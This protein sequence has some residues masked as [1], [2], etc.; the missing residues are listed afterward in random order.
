MN[1]AIRSIVIVGAAL[2]M[3]WSAI[4]FRVPEWQTAV[5][6]QFGKPIRT[7]QEPGLSWRI[8]FMQNVIFFEKRLLEYDATP[9]DVITKDKQQLSVDNF[10]RWRI[11]DPLVFHQSVLTEAQAQSRLDDVI[12]SALREIVA[13]NRLED[14]VSG[15][16]AQLVDYI[17]EE[18]NKKTSAFGIEI[19]DVR[20]KRTELPEKNEQSVFGRMRTERERQAKRFRAE[21][22]E[23]A[24]KIRS[25]AERERTV[26]LAEAAREAE[27]L[28]GK[29]EAQAID[30]YS[31][32]YSA[33]SDFYT[34]QRTLEA[35]TKTLGSGTT[36]VVTP[37][38]EF[39]SG[40]LSSE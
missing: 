12:Y 17:R 33:D 39:L 16:R 21:G 15:D 10:A 22:E 20:I 35:Y 40:L 29:G 38:S 11:V 30:I 25:M 2:A 4:F 32:A 19:V 1:N 6:F 37:N 34:F 5:V 13:Q 3:A 8:P 36:L 28:R 7:L 18:S 14:V 24:Q 23:E 27:L 31:D 26:L 9:K